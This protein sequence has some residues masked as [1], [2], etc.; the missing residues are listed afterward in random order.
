MSSRVQHRVSDQNVATERS[1]SRQ[2]LR[3]GL[4]FGA[5]IPVVVVGLL[6]G[7]SRVA[8]VEFGTVVF[9]LTGLTALAW[10]LFAGSG[11]R[12]DAARPTGELFRQ[13]ATDGGADVSRGRYAQIPL[14][15]RILFVLT[16]TVVLGWLVL[17][18]AL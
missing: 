2:V 1:R 9:G 10:L 18:A 3:A 12:M 5:A 15:A 8:S 13:S 6:Y 7:V 17:V 4:V 14:P 16:G 11:R